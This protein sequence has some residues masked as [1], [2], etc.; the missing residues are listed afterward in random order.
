[1]FDAVVPILILLSV[2]LM[3]FKPTPRGRRSA[4]TSRPAT[5][6]TF[7]T[8]IYGGYFGAAQGVI[9]LAVL[10]LAFADDLQRLNAVKNVLAGVANAVAAV[11]FIA[12]ADV[13]WEA[14][15]LIAV[16]SIVGALGRRAL[17]PQAAGR[18]AAADRD[19]GGHCGRRDP[20]RGLRGSGERQ[21][22]LGRGRV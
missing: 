15:A 18:V 17:R 12:V 3:A 20:D 21:R 2:A 22:R 1:M 13:A 10:R 9:L 19:R 16:G 8:G 5:G 7:L 11:L 14:A 6:G 4:T